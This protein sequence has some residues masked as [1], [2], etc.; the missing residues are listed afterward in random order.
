MADNQKSKL[1]LLFSFVVVLLSLITHILHRSFNMFEDYLVFNHMNGV[2]PNLV[3]LLNILLFIPIVLFIVTFIIHVKFPGLHKHLPF[4]NMLTLTFSSISI[5]AGGDGM[6][7]YHFSIFMVIAIIAYYESVNLILICTVIFAIQHFLGFYTAPEL[8]CGTSN[9][10]FGLLMV[11][12]IYLIFTSAA[13]I[14]QIVAKKQYTG[15]LLK[16]KGEQDR[17]LSEILD[18]LKTT[19]N[20]VVETSHNLANSVEHTIVASD[21]ITERMEEVAQGT[22]QQ[23]LAAKES[24]SAMDEMAIGIQKVAESS[25]VVSEQSNSTVREARNGE[26]SI[27]E[28]VKQM[29]LISKSVHNLSSTITLLGEKSQQIDEI[30]KVITTIAEQTNLLALNAAIEAAR[31]GEHGKGFAVVAD[32]VRKL[33]EQSRTSATEI[34]ELIREIQ[35]D[36]D[37]AVEAMKVGT[38]DVENGLDIVHQTGLMFKNILAA[39]ETV[40]V[41]I[42]EMSSIA[43]QMSA[44]SEEVSAS[45]DEVARIASTNADRTQD[46]ALSTKEQVD[47][48]KEISDVSTN[49]KSLAVELQDLIHKFDH[50]KKE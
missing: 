7:E 11:H 14:L 5:I 9:Y 20:R 38:K 3:L 43:E 13:T 27:E 47:A 33:A 10:T 1:M 44:S 16:E 21:R 32:E 28:A 18:N 15:K 17:E 37:K 39:S 25:N 48:L 50:N 24:A 45:V 19:S 49:L 46:I 4:L 23:S 12:A 35:N 30:L 29:E 6:V 34:T 26:K 31:A 41:Q 40:A 8:L 42:E 36:T 2:P 22:E